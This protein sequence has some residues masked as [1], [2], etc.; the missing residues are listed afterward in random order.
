[1][2]QVEVSG[3]GTRTFLTFYNGGLLFENANVI[4]CYEFSTL[5][6]Y[7]SYILGSIGLYLQYL[8]SGLNTDAPSLE[9]N[10]AK[11]S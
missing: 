4:L 2:L 5:T 7:P 1:M 3:T 8:I 6:L 10:A 9:A 11:V